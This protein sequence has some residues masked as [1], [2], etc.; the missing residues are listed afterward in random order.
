MRDILNSAIQNSRGNKKFKEL[1]KFPPVLRDISFTVPSEIKA[2]AV[3]EV[4][5][6]SSVRKLKSFRVFDFYPLE[7]K[8]SFTYTLEFYDD[9]KTFKDEEVNV[10]Q[11]TIIRELSKKLK[12]EL[13]K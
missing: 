13:R 2:S 7:D 8:K 1:P 12:A 5:K 11:E 6:S 4:L 10:L 3:N 9:E